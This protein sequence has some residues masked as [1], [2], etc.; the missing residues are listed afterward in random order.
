MVEFLK[1][2]GALAVAVIALLQPWVYAL[3]KKLFRQGKIEIHETGAIGV[4]YSSFGPT[5]DLNGTLRCLNAD[6]F[7]REIVVVVKKKKDSST[8]RFE[9]VAFRNERMTY[10][11]QP[12]GSIEL[13]YGFMLL[14]S[15][16]RRYS[17]TFR[18]TETHAE[19]WPILR[20][21]RQQWTEI[22]TKKQTKD[23]NI[24]LTD[25]R[26]VQKLYAEFEQSPTASE[27]FTKLDRL[28]YWKAGEYDLEVTAYSSKPDRAFSQ[29][30]RF[31]LTEQDVKAVRWNVFKLLE[32]ACY[33]QGYR[34]YYLAYSE[35]ENCEGGN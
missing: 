3:W 33:Q 4:G 12:E 6:L 35:Y 24:S 26:W 32:E 34:N 29:R 1:G 14:T 2:Y 22:V 31:K 23:P 30:W 13:P 27:S 15:S 25:E 8:H 5:V 10:A 28:C 17:I 11:G 20:D 19:M 7:V 21:V 18:D 9:W 16:P